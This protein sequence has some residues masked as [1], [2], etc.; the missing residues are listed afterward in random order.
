MMNIAKYDDT[1]KPNE[2]DRT[3]ILDFLFVQLGE[4][5][6]SKEDIEKALQYC[7]NEIESFGGFILVAKEDEQLLGVVLV[8]RTGMSGYIPEN[9]LVYIA[10]HRDYRGKGYGEQILKKAI[11]TAKGNLALHVESDNPAQKLYNKMGFVKKYI[12]MRLEK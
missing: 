7:L 5:G 8:N 11:G 3:I 12:E 1:N 9:I 2:I 4:Y 6:D 10:V